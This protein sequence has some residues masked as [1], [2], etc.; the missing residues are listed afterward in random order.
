M[1][2][3]VLSLF[4]LLLAATGLPSTA[5]AEA[6]I[7]S[8]FVQRLVKKRAADLAYV[9]TRVPS[10]YR[11]QRYEVGSRPARVTLR[12]TRATPAR[13]QPPWFTV[14]AT[15]YTAPLSAC[16]EGKQQTLQL[17]GNKVYWDGTT[18][19][20]CLTSPRGVTRV[21]VTGPPIDPMTF[22]SKF[23]Y[24]RVAASVKRIS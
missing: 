23:A 12:F 5:M 10:H 13:H 16:G 7:V 22:A 6:P 3:L 4:L 11:Y 8:P 19:W 9:P 15:P 21:A 17:G 14:T 24:G 20:R 18:A 2:R 1:R